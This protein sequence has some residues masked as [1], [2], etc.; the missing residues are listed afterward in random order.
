[1]SRQWPV[2]RDGPPPPARPEFAVIYGLCDP[3][4]PQRVRYVGSTHNVAVRY[5][6]HANF[7]MGGRKNRLRCWLQE[8]RKAGYWPIMV[9]LEQVTQKDRTSREA[10]WIERFGELNTIKPKRNK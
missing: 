4:E 5:S 6:G 7:T 1:M 9:Q 10:F 2:L 8:M 3:R